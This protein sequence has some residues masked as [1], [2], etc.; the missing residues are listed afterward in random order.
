MIPGHGA[1]Q[2]KLDCRQVLL[3]ETVRLDHAGGILPG[4]KSRH[5]QEQRALDV[6]TELGDR[7]LDQ[8]LW[9]ILIL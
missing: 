8:V 4:I 1:D 6:N 9:E 5:L 2:C 7:L 3:D